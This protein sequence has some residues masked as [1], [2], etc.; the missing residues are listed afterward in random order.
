MPLNDI[1]ATV[2]ALSLLLGIIYLIQGL[3]KREGAWRRFGIMAAVY[4]VTSSA[5]YLLT[6]PEERAAIKASRAAAEQRR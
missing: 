6:T 4:L 2:A 3:L 1:F 5:A